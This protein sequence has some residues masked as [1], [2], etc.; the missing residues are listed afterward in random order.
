MKYSNTLLE[1]LYRLKSTLPFRDAV[2]VSLTNTR[3]TI[4]ELD[5]QIL[6]N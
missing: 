5:V 3:W 4:K 1:P 2:F 6:L